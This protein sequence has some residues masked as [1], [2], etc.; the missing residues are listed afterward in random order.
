MNDK[1]VGPSIEGA[2]RLVQ[3]LQFTVSDLSYLICGAWCWHREMKDEHGEVCPANWREGG[4]II[5]GDPVSKLNY[6]ADISGQHE[7]GKANGTEL[8]PSASECLQRMWNCMY[9]TIQGKDR[10]IR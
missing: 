4:K 8:H 5:R 3:A 10:H 7:N 6:F 9:R 2:F 1:P